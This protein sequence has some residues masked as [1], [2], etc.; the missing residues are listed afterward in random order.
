[1]GS[2][3]PKF[4]PSSPVPVSGSHDDPPPGHLIS[5]STDPSAGMGTQHGTPAVHGNQQHSR[6]SSSGCQGTSR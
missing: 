6:Y 5:D 3:L 4:F 2:L 1:M